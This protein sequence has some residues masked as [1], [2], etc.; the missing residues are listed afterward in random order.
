MMLWVLNILS[1]C[2]PTTSLFSV[3]IL[4]FFYWIFLWL[5]F[6]T[7]QNAKHIGTI[8][9]RSIK[10]KTLNNF[11][12]HMCISQIIQELALHLRHLHRL[13]CTLY[14][15]GIGWEVGMSATTETDSTSHGLYSIL[16]L[17]QNLK[18]RLS[19]LSIII[20]N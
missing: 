16:Q 12:L 19:E 3:I 14:I 8:P 5:I 2:G 13:K 9:S 15:G 1:F 20:S 11:S 17:E 7:Q 18:I 4:T 10:K 6:N